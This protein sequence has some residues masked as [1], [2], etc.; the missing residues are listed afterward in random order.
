MDLGFSSNDEMLGLWELLIWT[1]QILHKRMQMNLLV[2]RERMVWIQSYC[3]PKS[4]CTHRWL[5]RE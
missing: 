1:K 2:V 5:F 3:L 4:S